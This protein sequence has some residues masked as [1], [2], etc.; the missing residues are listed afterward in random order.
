MCVHVGAYHIEEGKQKK[1]NGFLCD[2]SEILLAGSPSLEQFLCFGRLR[3][4][5][6]P[7]K[8]IVITNTSN[9]GV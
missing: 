5:T 1:Y 8:T 9:F 2:T 3:L 7:P 6:A 4:Q